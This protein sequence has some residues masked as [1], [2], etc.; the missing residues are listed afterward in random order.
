MKNRCVCFLSLLVQVQLLVSEADMENYKEIKKALD[1]LKPLVETS[2]L[3]L[4]K[5]PSPLTDI[6]MGSETETEDADDTDNV[7]V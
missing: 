5:P 2:E 1:T 4:Y 3:W 7:K 6:P